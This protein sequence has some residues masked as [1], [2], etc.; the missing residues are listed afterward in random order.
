MKKIIAF[1]ILCTVSLLV[2]SQ[3]K[4]VKSFDA[5]YLNWQN[6]D[7]SADK[8]MG[9]SVNKVYDIVLKN[10]KPKKT[11]VVAVIDSGVD[12]YHEDLVGRIWNNED[13]V[14]DNGIDDDK[15]GYIDDIHGWNFVGNSSG[16]NVT[17][18]NY[19]YARIV[20]MGNTNSPEYARAKDMY[21]K[22]LAERKSE[23]KNL[24]NF[25]KSYKEAKSII[26][27]KTGVDVK[28]L[29]DIEKVNSTDNSVLNAK[30]FLKEK[31][32]LGFTE[33]DLEF[34]KNRNYEYLNYYLNLEHNPREIV[35]DNP[36]DFND[37][38][39]GNNDVVGPRADHGTSVAAMIAAVRGNGIGIDGIATDVRIM[40]LRTTPNGDERDKDVALAIIYAVD[41]GADI[42]N[43]SFGKDFSPNK[44]FVDFA[45]KYAEEKNVL[46][47]HSAGNSGKNVDTN[48]NFPSDRYIDKTEAKNMMNVG[49]SSMDPDQN[50]AAVFS[51]YGVKHVDIFAPGFY[52]VSADTSSTYELT[53]G[54]S[55]A[56]PVV[57]G[58]AALLLSYY[59]D[60]SPEE[61]IAI[62][63]ESAFK[64]E[65]PKKVLVPCLD[66][67]KRK[68]VK[69]V[70]LSKSGGIVNAYSAFML[71]A[72]K[73]KM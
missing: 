57:T 51:N 68:K 45:I 27:K 17:Y 26:Y 36:N 13:E 66:C 62:L 35:G 54:T 30:A 2:L 10:L 59:P 70:D 25:E 52:L 72:E 48:E 41:N 5:K 39:Y 44:E 11:V 15:N 32:M 24:D 34:L 55:I 1:I 58:V 23:K 16:E 18:E 12:I 49:A 29:L 47:I 21:D 46:V 4:D 33:E 69:F 50:L 6:K 37:R 67:E 43:M 38:N 28:C 8:V 71:A 61:L 9:S 40:V 53:S 73:S 3:E 20:K 65:K 14:A 19:E 42:I 60:L 31:Y 22:E 64:P 56:G 7:F 63:M